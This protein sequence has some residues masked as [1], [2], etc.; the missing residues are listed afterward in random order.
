VF[1]RSEPPVGA[2]RKGQRVPSRV[3]A[4]VPAFTELQLTPHA[5][6]GPPLLEIVLRSGHVLRVPPGVTVGALR[7]V[8]TVLQGAAC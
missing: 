5:P 4:I 1:R 3:T 7:D 2:P 6:S 8:V